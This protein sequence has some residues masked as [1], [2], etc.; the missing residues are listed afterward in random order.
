MEQLTEERK[1][2]ISRLGEIGEK[3][4]RN[5]FSSQGLVV[6]D[7]LDVYDSTKDMTVYREELDEVSFTL[8][9]N[10]L[11]IEVKVCTP[12]V[13]KKAVTLRKKQLKKCREVDELYFITVPHKTLAYKYSGWILKID[14][15]TFEYEEYT[16]DDKRE[17]LGYRKMIAIK[18]GQ[19]AT[20]RIRELTEV[21]LEQLLKYT[22]SGE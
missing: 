1:N 14:P 6:E 21:E 13:H 12:Y 7:S 19:P 8:V 20:T 2:K 5:M 18:I 10:K 11:T 4:I 17:P 22:I 15:K 3:I 9:V 16:Q